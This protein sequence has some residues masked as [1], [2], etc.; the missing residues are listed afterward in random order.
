MIEY[1]LNKSK[2]PNTTKLKSPSIS[3]FSAEV[4]DIILTKDHKDY[5]TFGGSSSIGLIKYRLIESNKTINVKSLSYAIP[6]QPNNKNY[7]VI[8][9]LVLIYVGLPTSTST[10]KESSTINYYLSGININ[11]NSQINNLSDNKNFPKNDNHSPILSRSGDVVT[12]GRFQNSLKFTADNNGNPLTIIRNGRK[13][14]KLNGEFSEEDYNK[15]DSLIIFSSN[16]SV[17][18]NVAV[19]DLQSFKISNIQNNSK[20][21]QTDIFK[22]NEKI[23]LNQ[24]VPQDI[25]QADEANI[26]HIEYD[27]ELVDYP[28]AQNDGSVDEV[29]LDEVIVEDHISFINQT[30]IQEFKNGKNLTKLESPVNFTNA[31]KYIGGVEL[32]IPIQI[33]AMMDVIAFC[34]GTLGLGNFNG[35]NAV[36]FNG[37]R[38][39]NWTNDYKSGCPY[40]EVYGKDGKLKQRFGHWGRYQYD[41]PTWMT[42]AITNI[43]FSKRNQ[44]LICAKTI[45][46]RLGNILYDNLYKNMQDLNGVYG[47]CKILAKT[48]ASIPNGNSAYSY[49]SNN[50]VRIQGENIQ[51]LYN[52]AYKIYQTK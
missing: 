21:T 49:Y 17:D 12:E 51:K 31:Y 39:E 19:N 1:G 20:I 42:D 15:D 25:V 33:K 23:D 5:N 3:M 29:Q 4:M 47:I 36:V 45:K 41:R 46:R 26:E 8:G 11:N 40:Q 50:T 16:Q 43:P 35:Y 24:I 14:E 44:D 32:D 10:T 2:Q 22:N 6:L 52:I 30:Q 9:E 7:P 27:E 48:W 13:S 37:R 38:I 18:I 28:L 34:E